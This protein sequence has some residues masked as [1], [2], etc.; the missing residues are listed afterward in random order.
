VQ[1]VPS[2]ATVPAPDAAS[3]E[4]DS[5]SCSSRSRTDRPVGPVTPATAVTL[6]SGEGR[7]SESAVPTSSAGEVSLSSR[8]GV[9]SGQAPGGLETPGS[10]GPGLVGVEVVGLPAGALVVGPAALTPRRGTRT[11]SLRIEDTASLRRPVKT[12]AR[13][14]STD[15]PLG[16]STDSLNRSCTTVARPRDTHCFRRCHWKTTW[17]PR[18][19]RV[20]VPVATTRAPPVTAAGTDKVSTGVWIEDCVLSPEPECASTVAGVPRVTIASTVKT[21][22]KLRLCV[23]RAVRS[24]VIRPNRIISNRTLHDRPHP[25]LTRYARRAKA[26][27][28]RLARALAK[29]ALTRP[30]ARPPRTASCASSKPGSFS[31]VSPTAEPWRASH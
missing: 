12:I 21:G 28:E 26:F 15:C 31:T 2:I 14:F 9:G 1:P 16:T 13:T 19:A 3:A 8:T 27:G 25:L 17:A 6:V 7:A 23:A 4:A 18:G 22:T 10:V 20:A 30:T 5:E 24:I 11:V 29:S